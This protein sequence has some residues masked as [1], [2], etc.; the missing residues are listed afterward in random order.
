MP[1][2][3][4]PALVR[5]FSLGVAAGNGVGLGV[6]LAARP[7]PHV[8]FTLQAGRLQGELA[9]FGLAPA[10]RLTLGP[11]DGLYLAAGGVWFQAAGTRGGLAT[12]QTGLGAFAALGWAWRVLPAAEVYAGAGLGWLP[13]VAQTVSGA[14]TSLPGGVRPN[15]ELGVRWLL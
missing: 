2:D 10:L 14:T 13:S 5:P 11:A 6:E 1:A 12:S 7:G 8:G 9:G 4:P 15:A 3:M